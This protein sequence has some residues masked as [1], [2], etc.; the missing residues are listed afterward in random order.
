MKGTTNCH[1]ADVVET[2]TATTTTV[3]DAGPATVVEVKKKK[4]EK[5]MWKRPN[6][7]QCYL[8]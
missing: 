2:G 5:R 6:K 8:V 3:R 1:G 7:A 4:D